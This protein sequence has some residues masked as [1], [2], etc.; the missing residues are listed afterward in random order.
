MTTWALPLSALLAALALATPRE[1]RAAACCGEPAL[2][3]RLLDGELWMT[4]ARASVRPRFGAFDAEG[5]FRATD[6]T[7]VTT[8]IDAVVVARVAGPFEL[9]ASVPLVVNVR[10][11]PGVDVEAGAGVG[12]AGAFAR[13]VLLSST[14]HPWAPGI[15]LSASATLPTGAPPEHAEAA[16]ASDVFGEGRARFGAALSVDKVVADHL[17]LRADA[18]ALFHVVPGLAPAEERAAPTLLGAFAAGPVFSPVAVVVGASV[19]G[20]LAPSKRRR[21]DLSLSGVIDLSPTVAVTADVRAPLP[22][23]QLGRADLAT[24]RVTGGVRV[25]GLP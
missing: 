22:A 4:A 7:D 24:L 17:A 14:A 15:S 12:D 16:L 13:V 3:D 2:G 10:S 9:G 23:D 6:A 18:A 25:G 1:A 20:D 11:A 19:E 21:V 8:Q 5:S